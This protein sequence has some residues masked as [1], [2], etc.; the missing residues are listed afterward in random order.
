[1]LKYK[2]LRIRSKISY[3]A[4]YQRY[5]ISQLF[6]DQILKSDKQFNGQPAIFND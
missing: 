4:F 2:I 6:L 5:T 3:Y 1:M